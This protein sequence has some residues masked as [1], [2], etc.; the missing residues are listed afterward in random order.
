MVVGG[1][2]ATSILRLHADDAVPIGGFADVGI[3]ADKANET[4]ELA[5]LI[6]EER[7]R[8]ASP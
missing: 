4:I 1:R 3:D 6:A 7:I 2:L 5:A 8:A